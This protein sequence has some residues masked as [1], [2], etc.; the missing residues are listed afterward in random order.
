MFPGD[1]FVFKSAADGFHLWVVVSD[2]FADPAGALLVNL[3]T[4]RGVAFD[5]LSCVFRPGEHEWVKAESYVE[6]SAARVLPRA[7]LERLRLGTTITEYPAFPPHLLRRILDAAVVTP[8]L[9][10]DAIDLLKRQGLV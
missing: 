6:F 3:T 10:L 7:H 8:N 5:D 4:V 9:E 2:P 1:S